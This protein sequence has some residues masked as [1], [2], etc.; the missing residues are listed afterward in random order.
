MADP[1]PIQ[2]ILLIMAQE[3]P[4]LMAF[5]AIFHDCNRVEFR[6][7]YPLLTDFGAVPTPCVQGIGARSIL[8]FSRK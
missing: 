1:A 3:C 4:I 6:P 8:R 5:K 2:N 7:K